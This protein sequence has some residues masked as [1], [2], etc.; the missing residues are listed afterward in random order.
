M[1]Q[2]I[3]IS[4]Q[5]IKRLRA[6]QIRLLD[7]LDAICKKHSL[8]YWLDFGTFLGAVRSKDF[9][10]WDDDIDVSMPK[11][12]YKKFLKI[13]EEE[14][15]HDIFLQTPKTDPAYKDVHVK[16]RDCYSTFLEHH[17]SGNEPYHHGVYLDIFPSVYWPQMPYK[18]RKVLLYFIVRA[19][20]KAFVRKQK[21]FLNFLLYILLRPV[22][23]LFAPFK[24][25][26]IGMIP[27]DNGYYYSVPD[28]YL[29]PLKPVEFAGKEYPAPGDPANYLTCIYGKDF[30]TPPPTTNRV[31]HAKAIMLDTPC[32]HPRAIHKKHE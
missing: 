7:A 9:I 20:G 6:I 13:A 29:Y 16:L 12:D 11:A 23:W 21:P 3:N 26:E 17:E 28:K 8:V 22:L 24:G 14:L 25:R 27:E 4:E 2:E 15:P 32:N 31:P 19:Y 1:S 5:D 30:M 10:P 18:L